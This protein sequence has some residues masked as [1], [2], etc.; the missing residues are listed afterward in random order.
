MRGPA[1]A[2]KHGLTVPLQPSTIPLPMAPAIFRFGPYLADT[3]A[4]RVRRG[5]DVVELTPKLLDLLFHLLDHAGSLVT[6]EDLLE[7]L[8][9]GAN[10]TENALSQA[11]S[12]LRHALGD[13]AAA[14]TFI[15]TVARRGYRF[16]APVDSAESRTPDA[17]TPAG[18]TEGETLRS[19][20]VLD[21]V[22]V[23]G[24][25]DSAWLSAGIAETVTGDLRALGQ[26][27]V[28]DRWRV[29]E[30]TRRTGGSLHDI[31]ATLRAG[32]AVVGSYQRRS[33]RIR[34]TARVVDIASGEALADAKVDGPFDQIFALQDQVVAQFAGDLG[35]APAS[36][37]PVRRETP[38]LEAY[39]ACSEGWVR[40]ESLD[41][42]EMP[43]AIADFEHAAAADPHYAL[44]HTGL[45]NAAIVLYESTR[46]DNAPNT[47]LLD[48]AVRH[49][50]HAATLDPSLAEAHATLAHALVGLWRMTDAAAAARRAVALEP[51]NWRHLF[52]LGHASWGEDRLRAAAGTLAL[53]PDFAFAHFQIAM[54]HVARGQLHRAETVLRHGAAVQDRQIGRQGRYPALG[55]HWLLGLVRL[56]Q[57]D[58]DEAIAELERER[59]LA[60]PHRL[61]GREYALYA[62]QGIGAA[63]VRAGRPAEAMPHFEEALSLYAHHAPS[64]LGL[65][66]ANRQIGS[67]REAAAA[68]DRLE[69]ALAALTSARP[70][71]AAMIRAQVAA[72]HHDTEGAVAILS[73]LL[74]EAQP[75]FA[76]WTLPV[77]PFLRDLQVSEAFTG[78]LAQL[79]A[80]AG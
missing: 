30:A 72:A 65:A 46:S 80:R 42:R 40:L 41:V 32:L 69:T 74:A 56:A 37:L 28:V 76:G 36:P 51:S 43:R 67:E 24:E 15:K 17:G 35:L 22:N 49:A 59:H 50:R 61:Y 5:T 18:I 73:R 54:V 8:W 71:E 58:V 45:A 78:V 7:A 25:P 57:D 75:G 53:Y 47:G 6:K 55:L 39:R 60:E 11:V 14:P 16:I 68:M 48:R 1:P 66:L 4:Y 26:F 34:I 52:R 13:D 62:L 44:A 77:E 2:V 63:L 21:F 3:T 33:D 9:P 38:S 19:I 27:R 64:L 79:A 31:A 12:E 70:I 10:V 23:T 29:M 20:A